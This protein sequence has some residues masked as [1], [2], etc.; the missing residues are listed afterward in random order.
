VGDPA[1]Q[2][3]AMLQVYFIDVSPLEGKL[4]VLRDAVFAFNETPLPCLSA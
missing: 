3:E 2:L 1:L 4:A